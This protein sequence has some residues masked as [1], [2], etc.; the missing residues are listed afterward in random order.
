MPVDREN[1]G[2]EKEMPK[3]IC[4]KIVWALKIK[5]ITNAI[6]GIGCKL[7]WTDESYESIIVDADYIAKHNPYAGGY[8][9]VYEDGYK[10]FSPSDAFEKGYKLL[11]KN[12]KTIAVKTSKIDELIKDLNR[13]DRLDRQRIDIVIERLIELKKG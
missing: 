4:H 10:S 6:F 5:L 8:Y 11:D 12:D 3:Y 1:S 13:R 2:N 9:V 7:N